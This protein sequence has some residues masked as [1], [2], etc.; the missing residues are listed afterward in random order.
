MKLFEGYG[1]PVS[2]RTVG[3]IDY[4]ALVDSVLKA[5]T[6]V[7]SAAQQTKQQQAAANAAFY[8]AQA[9]LMYNQPAAAGA[10]T[11]STTF[12]L[13]MPQMLMVG[14]GVVAIIFLMRRK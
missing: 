2:R 8:N 4:G 11:G 9:A 6:S 12:G 14:A 5:G 3:T 13:T 10:A 7:Y 1:E